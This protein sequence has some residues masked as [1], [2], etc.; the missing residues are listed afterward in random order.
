MKR[1][2]MGTANH[3]SGPITTGSQQYARLFTLAGWTVAYLSDPISP[4]QLVRPRSWLYNR[5]KF[6]LWARGGDRHLEGGLFAYNPLS[7]LP[8]FN[9]PILRS[10][11]AVRNALD[12]TIPRLTEK[13]AAE[14]FEAPDM[15]WVDHLTY[16]GLV[17]RVSSR[18]TVYRLADD[19]KLFPGPYPPAL[20]GRFPELLR[21]VDLVVATGRRL[22]ELA[23][24]HR[25]DGVLYLPNGVDYQH[26]AGGGPEPTELTRIPRPRVLYVGSLEPW[27]DRD[28][29]ARAARA[30]P[31]FQF[32]VV[33]PVRV[34]VGALQNLPNV[35]ILGARPYDRVPGFTAH[36]DVGIVPFRTTAPMQAVHP[37]KVYEYLAAGLPV[38]STDWDELRAMEA[39]LFRATGADE[40]IQGLEAAVDGGIGS[41]AERR[42]Y[43]QSNSWAS[44]FETLM[45]ALPATGR[46]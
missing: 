34:D 43:A 40:F 25:D 14:G 16:E 41:L 44:R 45:A 21:R 23:R 2:V 5:H 13:L 32:V 10:E 17:D 3:W 37:I 15:L 28:L 18:M 6:G 38:V 19:P 36:A 35:H 29:M 46:L 8:V 22:V 4:F 42:A 33:G 26:F 20:L 31:S 11:L 1:L 9:A 30:L 24:Q 12:L 27:L 39:P 7:L